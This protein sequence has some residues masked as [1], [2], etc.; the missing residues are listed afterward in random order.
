MSLMDTFVQVFEFDT[1]QAD[2][3]FDRVRRSTDDIIADMKRA[4]ESASASGDSFSKFMQDLST[5]LQEIT[6]AET[7]DL[8]INT[9][10]T[11]E[12][13]LATR[14]RIS[15]VE[16]A[17]GALDDQRNSIDQG[18][19]NN[20]RVLD[21]L[22]EQ[23]G[24]LQDELTGLNAELNTLTAAE[25]KNSK[26]K[27]SVDAIVK[28]LN[29]D[30]TRFVETMRTKGVQAAI[31][32]AKAQNNLQRELTETQ[33]KYKEAG[34]T[35]A[36]FATKAL[37]AVGVFMGLSSMIG[38]SISRSADIEA[39]DKLS[40][41]INVTTADV[42]AF[43]GSM[44]ELGGT[45]EAAQADLTAMAKSFGFAKN[46]MEKVL[47]TADKVQGM[48]FDKAKAT[49]AGLG[50]TD[51]KT[52]ELMMKGRKELERMMG[53]QK[54]YS[55]ISKESIEQSIKFNKAMQGFKQSSGLL[56]NSFLEMVIPIL[57]K[58]LEWLNKFVGFCKENK[59]LVIGFFVAL[60][61]A[62]AVFYVP[63]MLSAA[64]ATLAATWPILAI[65]AVIALL[66]AAF[67]FVYDDIMNF[68][69]GNDSM[70]GR[71]LD[72]YPELKA[73]IMALW[74]TFKAFFDFVIALSKVV[75]DV[76]VA[77]FNF[78]V[79]G[80]KQFWKWL[81]E[82]IDGLM[83]W[84]KQF[85]G[86]FNTVSDAVVG[87]FK[88]LWAQI[89]QYLGWINDGLDAIKKGWSTVKGWFGFED[90]EV[91]QTVERKISADGTI[92]HQIPESPKL[93]EDDTA[94]LVQGLSQQI[95]SMS[96]NPMNPMTSQAIS[97]QSSTTNENTVNVGELNINTQATDAQGIAKD[98]KGEL[99]SQL[100]DLAHQTSSGVGK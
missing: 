61:S 83:G 75:A 24:S 38:E 59:Q 84:G 98:A 50:V 58:G 76:A 41:Q 90:A 45:R 12:K 56:K 94:L 39:M 40:K 5:S 53:I 10:D 20:V 44:T 13:L 81:N 33:N 60:G 29:A 79:D 73:V 43:A 1:R 19:L 25:T 14:E 4:Q 26:A 78:I 95:N 6:G 65:I 71:I 70:I 42:D 97:N 69:D 8:D 15:D 31:E 72:E 37:G 35:V 30:Y 18:L 62:I 92:E 99:Q 9:H 82:F 87:I 22:N 67:A 55:G 51:D 27:A 47:Q 57:A 36:G 11:E 28:A 89:K 100:Q 68:I 77:A 66:A 52:V 64:A 74:E 96:A 21:S 54:E 85:E 16:V 86:V 91:T 88:W 3:A 34:S 2:G 17:M 63:S 49:L 7:F 46:S 23:Y 48:K 32:E 80:G 93:S